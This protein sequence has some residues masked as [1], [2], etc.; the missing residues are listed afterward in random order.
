MKKVAIALAT[1]LGAVVLLVAACGTAVTHAD[2]TT[3]TDACHN[4]ATTMVTVHTCTAANPSVEFICSHGYAHQLEPGGFDYC[5]A[6]KVVVVGEAELGTAYV[7]HLAAQ[8]RLDV[9][10]RRTTLQ[11]MRFRCAR[12]GGTRLVASH[13]Y[14]VCRSVKH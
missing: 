7:P 12:L 10:M 2:T 4:G 8:T 9:A 5:P 13:G 6:P 11:S 3:D 14:F 1:I